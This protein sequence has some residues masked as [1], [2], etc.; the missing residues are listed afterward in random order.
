MISQS[1]TEST[2]LVEA[3]GRSRP[4]AETTML[5]EYLY[6]T[7][8]ASAASASAVRNRPV[9]RMTQE[10]TLR[11]GRESLRTGPKTT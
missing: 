9:A 10:A 7:R 5:T 1:G 2:T 8:I 3:N 4:E 6:A 11:V